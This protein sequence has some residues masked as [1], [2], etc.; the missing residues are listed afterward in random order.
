MHYHFSLKG[1]NRLSLKIDHIC[2]TERLKIP[3]N[4]FDDGSNIF[5]KMEME[6]LNYYSS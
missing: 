3:L 1:M 2:Y 4:L 5:P 6:I